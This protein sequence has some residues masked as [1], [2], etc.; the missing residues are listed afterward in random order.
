MLGIIFNIEIIMLLF[1][2]ELLIPISPLERILKR[3][4]IFARRLVYEH[5]KYHDSVLE[6]CCGTCQGGAAKCRYVTTLRIHMTQRGLCTHHKIMWGSGCMAPFA[7]HLG[8][9]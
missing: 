5:L 6:R 9:K 1:V 4:L 2:R 7:L 3:W 8:N